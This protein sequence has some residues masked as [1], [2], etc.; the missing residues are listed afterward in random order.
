M[1]NVG[2]FLSPTYQRSKSRHRKLIKWTIW[3]CP[4]NLDR[5]ILSVRYL[6]RVNLLVE[7]ICDILKTW[8]H[9]EGEMKVQGDLVQ[10][11]IFLNSSD[12]AGRL[13]RVNPC[14]YSR[15]GL[16]LQYQLLS[17]AYWLCYWAFESKVL[18]ETDFYTVFKQKIT[19]LFI[20]RLSSTSLNDEE[21]PGSSWEVFRLISLSSIH[22][23]RP[24]LAV[25]VRVLA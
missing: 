20:A 24:S 13:V 7:F 22:Q 14:F 17:R 10:F 5:I 16:T 25:P 1:I 4:Y 19:I 12:K 8:V 11:M 21:T 3:Y 23:Y 2:S 15:D 18:T 6:V 9:D